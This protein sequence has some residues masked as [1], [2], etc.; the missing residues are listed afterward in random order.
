MFY[1]HKI[2]TMFAQ[3]GAYLELMN[4]FGALPEKIISTDSI[5]KFNSTKPDDCPCRICENYIPDS[6]GYS[7]SKK[8]LMQKCLSDFKK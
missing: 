8:V 4:G 6:I 1:F 3:F 2:L 5:E 7:K